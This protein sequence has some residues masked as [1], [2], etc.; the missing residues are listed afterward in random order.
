M[1]DTALTALDLVDVIR[2]TLGKRVSH[3]RVQKDGSVRFALYDAIAVAGHPDEYGSGGNWGFSV[4][5]GETV[6]VSTVLG[7][8]LSL[9]RSRQDIQT[10]LGVVDRYARLRLGDEYLAAYDAALGIAPA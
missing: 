6:S 2:E 8:K 7:V 1:T 3:A 5:L 10:A 9:K 4:L